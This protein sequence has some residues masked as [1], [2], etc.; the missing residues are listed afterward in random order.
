MP[1][2]AWDVRAQRQDTERE[3]EQNLLRGLPYR[4]RLCARASCAPRAAR[5]GAIDPLPSE[6]EVLEPL[7]SAAGASRTRGT[8]R[9]HSYGLRK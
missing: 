5:C 7:L 6:V 3:R 1:W 9:H 4:R 8:R 2:G